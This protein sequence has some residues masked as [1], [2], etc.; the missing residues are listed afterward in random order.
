MLNGRILEELERNWNNFLIQM[1][2][3]KYCV[4]IEMK[5]QMKLVEVLIQFMTYRAYEVNFSR[6][7]VTQRRAGSAR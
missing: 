7:I 6:D 4:K 2:E 3:F 1:F 5:I